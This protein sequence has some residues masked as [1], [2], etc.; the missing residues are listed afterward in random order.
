[1]SKILTLNSELLT[2][3][4]IPK[5]YWSLGH[6]TYKGSPEALEK[7]HTYIRKESFAHSHG[8]GLL[9][10]GPAES[11]KTFLLT[12]VL[13][14]LLAKGR[15][16]SYFKAKTIVDSNFKE[17]HTFDST[18]AF[19][20]FI[21]VDDLCVPPNKGEADAFLRLVKLRKDEGRPM[22]VATTFTEAEFAHFY[23]ETVASFFRN[24]TT[25]VETTAQVFQNASDAV[26]RKEKVC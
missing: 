8:V 24:Y 9:I 14:C 4:Y 11:Y 3:A 16:V 5:A 7:I 13:K 18:F 25:T 26:K 2:E 21:G 22:L 15:D 1:M 20:D 10:R 19:Y 17:S 6:K 12:Y 23:G